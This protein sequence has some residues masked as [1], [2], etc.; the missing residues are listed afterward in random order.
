MSPSLL[1]RFLFSSSNLYLG[2]Q[3]VRSNISNLVHGLMND[4]QIATRLL[5][6]RDKQFCSRCC[7]R[8][9]IIPVR[10]TI[11][12]S[13]KFKPIDADSEVC[14]RFHSSRTTPH[15][16]L[17]LS[18]TS[19]AHICMHFACKQTSMMSIS[20]RHSK[21]LVAFLRRLAFVNTL[22]SPIAQD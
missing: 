6:E 22:L 20:V 18:L 21:K 8:C 5:T 11:V 13:S 4:S 12:L 15:C 3:H 16:P 7:C 10:S 14:G 17:T 1:L 2:A 9:F 19:S